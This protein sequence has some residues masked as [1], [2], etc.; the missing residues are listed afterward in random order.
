MVGE[1]GTKCWETVS[2]CWKLAEFFNKKFSLLPEDEIRRLAIHILNAFTDNKSG[3][4]FT[5]QNSY[6]LPFKFCLVLQDFQNLTVRKLW[7]S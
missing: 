2:V 6:E 4:V 5:N 3:S 7:I 1:Y